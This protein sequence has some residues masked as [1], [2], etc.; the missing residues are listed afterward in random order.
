[1]IRD[2]SPIVPE[3]PPEVAAAGTVTVT[4]WRPP[5]PGDH[6]CLVTVTFQVTVTSCRRDSTLVIARYI[7][8][9]LDY[10][11]DSRNI[12]TPVKWR[13]QS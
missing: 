13:I 4:A 1:V 9:E 12:V 10:F 6:P 3:R 8:L 7:Q 2:G 5:L 11:Y